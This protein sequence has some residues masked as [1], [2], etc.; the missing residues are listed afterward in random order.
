MWTCEQLLLCYLQLQLL[1]TLLDTS[2]K[3]SIKGGW[4]IYKSVM[5]RAHPLGPSGVVCEILVLQV[6]YDVTFTK[7]WCHA[8]ICFESWAG[9]RTEEVTHTTPTHPL[10]CGIFCGFY[11]HFCIWQMDFMPCVPSVLSNL[12]LH[13]TIDH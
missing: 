10:K 4:T 9:S 11:S 8:W 1:S 3:T 2:S 6:S 7:T 5:F 13:Y 12:N